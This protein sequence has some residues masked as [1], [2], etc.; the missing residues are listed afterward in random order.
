MVPVPRILIVDDE[1][2]ILM[3]VEGWLNELGCEVVGPA[4]SV[5]SGSNLRGARRSMALSST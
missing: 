3:L 2:L 5:G 4:N 1:P